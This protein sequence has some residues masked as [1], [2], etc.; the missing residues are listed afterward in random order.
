MDGRHQVSCTGID[1]AYLG[2][3]RRN[4]RK[5]D[6]RLTMADFDERKRGYES[7]FAHDEELRF[8]ALSRGNK[9][10]GLWAAEQLGKSGDEA[11]AYAQEVTR[12]GFG[13]GSEEVIG[14]LVDDL[15]PRADEATI[16]SQMEA[17]LAEA[18]EQVANAQGS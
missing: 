9:L 7:K 11:E 4:W 15:G 2:R 13:A 6:R 17:A 14:K 1:P 3:V 16:R 8:R 10:L 18:A 12:M 5:A